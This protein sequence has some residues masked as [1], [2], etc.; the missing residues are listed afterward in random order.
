MIGIIGPNGAGKSTTVKI[1][2]GIIQDY[3]GDVQVAGINLAENVLEVKK[4][5][6]YIPEL[7]EMYDLRFYI[8][9][10]LISLCS[11][12]LESRSF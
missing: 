9:M 3:S 11:L 2:A 12:R 6:G 8:R 10:Q 4:K 5:I 7:P 1:L